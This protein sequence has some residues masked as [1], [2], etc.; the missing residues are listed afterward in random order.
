MERSVVGWS[1]VK[2]GESLSNRVSTIIRRYID[3]IKFAVY[4]AFYFVTFFQILLV[5]LLSLYIWL[6]CFFMILFKFV[7]YVFLL[8]CLC[9]LIITYVLSCVFC[10]IVLFY[11]LFVCKCVLYYCHRVSIQL[12]LTNIS[13]GCK[14]VLECMLSKPRKITLLIIAGENLKFRIFWCTRN[15]VT[16]RQVYLQNN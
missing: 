8:L 14:S 4:M 7:N 9:I 11:V 3:H 16:Y 15:S 1:V 10:F 13:N 6:L 5:V 12:K 2:W